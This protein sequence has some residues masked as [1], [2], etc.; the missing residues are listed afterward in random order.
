MAS[1]ILL[2][3]LQSY[4]AEVHFCLLLFHRHPGYRYFSQFVHV[5][6]A[7]HCPSY[8]LHKQVFIYEGSE[9]ICSLIQL[10]G[11][12]SHC[13]EVHFCLLLFTLIIDI[14]AS[15][16]K[17][18]IFRELHNLTDV[19]IGYS[20]PQGENQARLVGLVIYRLA[21]RSECDTLN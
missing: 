7:E 2:N 20:N 13:A 12:H 4:C 21:K 9:S 15:L 10:Q 19:S 11:L 16:F 3:G 6:D 18:L 14:S 5:V 1:L 17:V 8:T